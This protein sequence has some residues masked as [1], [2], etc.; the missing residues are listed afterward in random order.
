MIEEAGEQQRP[1]GP[2]DQQGAH[3]PAMYPVNKGSQEHPGQYEHQCSQQ[4]K[5]SNYPPLL[6][7]Q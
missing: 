7:I 5:G 1:R 3:E 4:V 2:G 6:I